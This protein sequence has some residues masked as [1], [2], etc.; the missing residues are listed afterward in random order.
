MIIYILCIRIVVSI[1]N[2]PFVFFVALLAC[3]G[4]RR[5]W[6]KKKKRMPAFL[7]SLN[8]RRLAKRFFSF[9]VTFCSVR[10]AKRKDFIGI[11]CPRETNGEKRVAICCCRRRMKKHTSINSTI[12]NETNA[13][14]EMRATER[15]GK[16]SKQQQRQ[17]RK[18]K[19]DQRM[20]NKNDEM[21]KRERNQT[22][23][24]SCGFLS[25]CLGFLSAVE[26]VL[27]FVRFLFSCIL[28]FFF[29]HF[30]F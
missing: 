17:H 15:D 23:F 25:R 19:W 5:I 22:K 28:P 3:A 29:F 14:Y 18:K 16:E 4:I 21:A 10:N 11:K 7:L 9:T 6:S 30:P 12:S 2:F 20:L 13:F 1:L 24:P 26:C 8:G 27:F